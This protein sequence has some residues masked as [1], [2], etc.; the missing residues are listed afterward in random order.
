MSKLSALIKRYNNPLKSKGFSAYDEI[1][2]SKKW[3][4]YSLDEIKIKNLMKTATYSE[5]FDAEKAL[6]VVRRKIEYMYRHKNFEISA[7]TLYYIK[8][9][10]LISY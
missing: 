7:A 6:I 10:S 1:E 3:A 2:A 5:K 8:L 9:K 4:E